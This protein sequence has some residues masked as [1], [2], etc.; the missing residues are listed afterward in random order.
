MSVKYNLKLVLLSGLL[1]IFLFSYCKKKPTEPPPGPKS[2]MLYA[3]NQ[4]EGCVY[5]IDTSAD[6]LVDTICIGNPPYGNMLLGISPDGSILYIYSS[7][8]HAF[9][10][11]DTKTKEIKY[12]GSNSSVY[13]SPDGKYLFTSGC[14]PSGKGIGIIDACTHQVVYSDSAHK[15]GP[16]SL[17]FDKNAPLVYGAIRTGEVGVFNHQTFTWERTFEIALSEYDGV[18]PKFSA[19]IL[20]P[21]GKTLYFTGSFSFYG[22][23]GV[24][25]I[26][27][28]SLKFE[29]SVLLDYL[30]SLFRVAHVAT[31]V[32]G[33]YVYITDPGGYYLWP[34]HPYGEI[35]VFDTQANDFVSPISTDT[36]KT[37]YKDY[38]GPFS[39][40]DI[41]VSPDGKKAY[42]SD[43]VC[44]VFVIDLQQNKI[45]HLIEVENVPGNLTR[46]AI[47]SRP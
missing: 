29:Y 39:T 24:Y 20:S 35:W 18:K 38:E 16:F 15:I 11:I 14:G 42:V 8:H 28:D 3:L 34:P 26:T 46:L 32:D 41:V 43:W 22:V 45:T 17:V 44:I 19:L 21:D 2:Y 10:E 23:F 6:T 27:G 30:H 1:F 5:V 4:N 36:I 47:Q 9:Y 37:E 31:S 12:K 40:C 25:D 7:E 13:I 33:R